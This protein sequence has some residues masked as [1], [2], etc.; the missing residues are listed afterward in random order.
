MAR[1]KD[2]HGVRILLGQFGAAFD[3]GEEEGNRAGGEVIR[4]FHLLCI[5]SPAPLS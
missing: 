4:V 1:E 3:I 2:R 5:Q